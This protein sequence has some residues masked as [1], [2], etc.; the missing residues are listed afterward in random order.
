MN[1]GSLEGLDYHV[2]G[3]SHDNPR[4][5]CTHNREAQVNGVSTADDRQD[6]DLIRAVARRDRRA[7]ET[8]YYRHSPQLGRYLMR[9]LGQQEV[10]EEVINDVMLVVW[11]NAERYDPA[12]ARLTTWLFGIAHNKALKAFAYRR[13]L[14]AEIQLDPPDGEFEAET[15]F[16]DSADGQDPHDPERTLAGREIGRL[17]TVALDKLSPEHRC[18]IE[19]AFSENC[20]YQEIAVIADC[21]VN[22]V[23][24]RMF[25]A[26]KHLAQIL[27]T[28]GLTDAIGR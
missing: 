26:R 17:L 5:L 15:D 4:M 3:Q 11:Q 14:S 16:D 21:P 12:I 9:L 22:T 20:S 7:F 25:H 23:K 27:K 2:F 18:V 1:L 24:T 28:L 6:V 8:L 19:L 10:V 13:S